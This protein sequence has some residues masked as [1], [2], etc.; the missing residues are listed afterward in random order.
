MIDR[1]AF[2]QRYTNWEGDFSKSN[3]LFTQRKNE[4]CQKS[5][6]FS[7][8][9]QEAPEVQV[10]FVVTQTED[11]FVKVP[12]LWQIFGKI[13]LGKLRA[14]SVY[15]QIVIFNLYLQLIK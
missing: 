4:S 5:S 7:T 2:A 9:A 1:A 11:V 3:H 13:G 15:N 10:Q 8:S 6:E 14:R 12:K